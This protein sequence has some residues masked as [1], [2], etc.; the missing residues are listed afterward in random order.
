ID[1]RGVG[2]AGIDAYVLL[3]RGRDYAWSATSSGA[4]NVDTF[5]LR[6]CDPAGGPATTASMG[7][8]HDGHCEPITTFDH[9]EAVAAIGGGTSGG[10]LRWTVQRTADYGPVVRRGTLADG[11]PIAI[12]RKRSTYGD[13]ISSATGFRRLNDPS[14][15]KAGYPAF[16][17]AT[18]AHIGFT[19]NWFY[20]DGVT[21]G[22]EHSCKCPLRA[23]GVDP[24][25]PVWGTGKW[26]WKGYL[27]P[28]RQPH[29]VN[30]SR[31]YITSWNNKQAPGFR[32]SDGQ[33]SYGAVHRVELLNAGVRRVFAGTEKRGVTRADVVGLMMNAATLDL[34]AVA[35]LPR[36]LA[37]LAPGTEPADL[38]PRALDLRERLEIWAGEATGPHRH[39]A[40]PG[41]PYRDPVAIAALDAW[42]PRATSAIFGD[43][44]G[45]PFESLGLTVDDS[46]RGHGGSAFDDGSYSAVA[47]DL[48]VVTGRP[49][50]GAWAR[51]FCGGGD[52]TACRTVLWQSLGATVAA[53]DQ[54]FGSPTVDAW[55]RAPA[56]DEIR[57]QQVVAGMLPMEWQ[58]R[59]TFQQV[60]Q[61]RSR[62]VA[63]AGSTSGGGGGALT[64]VL[65]GLVGLVVAVLALWWARRRLGPGFAGGPVPRP[66]RG[67][68]PPS[69]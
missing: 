18:G 52:L 41:A 66:A 24:D 16:R 1:A 11:T 65:A 3:G 21:I 32:A 17:T 58:N 22:Y 10:T 15:M 14:L 57:F 69:R 48:S 60:V 5:V 44:T 63:G 6:L 61:L 29:D 9:T 39:G 62:G 36:L 2:F 12:A 64:I 26:D 28:S 37:V 35:V 13:E 34:R 20:V 19:F 30:P 55:Q 40:T 49:V 59:P 7:Y 53:L 56:D 42:W 46:P 8:E 45:A 33:F 38:D 68:P 43:G 47:T 4:D 67:A 23:R 51:A 27:A 50:A 25:L 54:Q 31:G